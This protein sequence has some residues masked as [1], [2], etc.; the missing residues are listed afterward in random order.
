MKTTNKASK[1][2]S[3]LIIVLFL[4]M[5]LAYAFGFL[6]ANAANSQLIAIYEVAKVGDSLSTLKEKVANMPQTWISASYTQNEMIFSAPLKVGST[7]WLLRIQAETDKITCVRIHTADSI[8][9]HPPTA[10]P[11]KGKCH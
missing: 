9:Y 2:W 11:D 6:I 8:R 1:I 7:N 4:G 5:V 10:P 3:I